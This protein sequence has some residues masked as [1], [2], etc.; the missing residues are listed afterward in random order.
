MAAPQLTISHTNRLEIHGLQTNIVGQPK[1]LD[2]QSPDQIQSQNG[3][4]QNLIP[5]MI[6]TLRRADLQG[7][8]VTGLHQLL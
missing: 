7:S 4:L 5:I 6:L 2:S 3:I 1:F 8:G